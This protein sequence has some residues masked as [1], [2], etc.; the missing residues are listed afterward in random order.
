MAEILPYPNLLLVKLDGPIKN[1]C[2]ACGTMFVFDPAF[3]MI[4]S[5]EASGHSEDCK[6][7]Q[8]LKRI[9]DERHA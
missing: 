2:V 7:Y 4:V 5:M 9:R 8:S 6:L 3:P 1:T